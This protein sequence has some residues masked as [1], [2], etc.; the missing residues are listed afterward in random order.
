ML[1]IYC[2]T[3][4]WPR[5]AT[6]ALCN[7]SQSRLIRALGVRTHTP[8]ADHTGAEQGQAV[9]LKSLQA[10]LHNG[11]CLLFCGAFCWV[12]F[13]VY[14]C[15]SYF[16]FKNSHFK[17]Q[18]QSLY[19]HINLE[20]I[21]K[22]E[23]EGSKWMSNCYCQQRGASSESHDGWTSG[24]YGAGVRSF[25]TLCRNWVSCIQS[26]PSEDQLIEL[27]SL[28]VRKTKSS[29]TQNLFNKQHKT[30]ISCQQTAAAVVD[31]QDK[32]QLLNHFS[33]GETRPNA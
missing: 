10:N 12:V 32:H 1:F 9:N 14:C 33:R 29:E 22:F 27:S 28:T 2:G 7:E 30:E 21:I 23:D 31:S 3:I 16:Q 5:S 24:L 6:T 11:P 20:M 18:S 4:K 26:S 19:C 8:H 17:R 15:I 13:Y 25:I